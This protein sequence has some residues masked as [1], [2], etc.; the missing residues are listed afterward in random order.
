MAKKVK[1]ETNVDLQE[2]MKNLMEQRQ[3]LEVTIIKITGAIEI[4]NS[5]LE[6]KNAD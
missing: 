6:E 3:Q 1:K 2:K 5:M 4:L